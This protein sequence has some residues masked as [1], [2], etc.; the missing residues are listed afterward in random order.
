[1]DFSVDPAAAATAVKIDIKPGG[2]PNSV[3]PRASGRISVAIPTTGAA[4][5][6]ATFDTA[7]V[8]PATVRFGASGTDA[9]PV[10]DAL[11]DVDRDGDLDLILHFNIQDIGIH[12]GDTSATLT[13]QTP[14][15]AAFSATDAIKTVGCQ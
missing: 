5:N 13:G 6:F 14:D 10:H 2:F 7:T 12:C 3:N 4:D 15:G 11:E 8:D 9:S 1:M